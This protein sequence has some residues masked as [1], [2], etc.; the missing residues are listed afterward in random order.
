MYR[1]VVSAP[2]GKIITG[3]QF[4]RRQTAVRTIP[5]Y[6]ER[7]HP[8]NEQCAVG[9]LCV[10]GYC[11]VSTN[12]QSQESSATAQEVSIREMILKNPTWKFGGIYKDINKSG[13]SRN[14]RDGFNQMME[15]A[16]AGKID[17][18]ITK[19][20]S[21]FA[22][23]TVDALDCVKQLRNLNPSVGVVFMKEH[24]FTLDPRTDFILTLLS[25]LAEYESYSIAENIRWGIRKRFKL[26]IPQINLKRMLG[27]D[28][29]ENGNWVVNQ[30]QAKIVR[31]IY[32]SYAHGR[33]ASG[34]SK[35]LNNRGIKTINGKNWCTTGILCILEN[36]KYIGDLLI[37]KTYTKDV[38]NHRPVENNGELLRYYIMNHHEA[39][40]KREDWIA[41]QRKICGRARKRKEYN[42]VQRFILDEYD[43]LP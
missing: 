13:T 14:H 17:Y 7:R 3:S 1:T 43:M 12:E 41:V 5:A 20:I 23:N 18:I 15:D 6:T 38:L 10:A 22:R 27:Y 8:A 33:S 42:M 19:S 37:Q 30:E 28:M 29:G 34:I 36:E 21:R 32:D 31:D 39:I 4:G 24:I 11:R 16:K 25:M 35:D 26:G 9:Q 40:I 2:Q